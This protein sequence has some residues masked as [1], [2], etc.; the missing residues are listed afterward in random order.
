MD[1]LK[2][3]YLALADEY[4]AG[5]EDVG[6]EAP[7]SVNE[8]AATCPKCG[9]V[10][11]TSWIEEDCR[12]SFCHHCQLEFTPVLEGTKLLVVHITERRR[13]LRKRMSQAACDAKVKEIGMS[14]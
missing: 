10:S 4:L 14:L 11:F 1:L 12:C 13:R 9:K 7:P 8:T 2:E 5:V 6:L 3:A